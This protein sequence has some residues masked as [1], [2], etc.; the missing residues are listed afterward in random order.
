MRKTATAVVFIMLFAVLSVFPAAAESTNYNVDMPYYSYTYDDNDRVVQTPAPYY[1]EKTVSGSDIGVGGFKTLSDIFYDKESGLIYLTD[2][3]NNRVIVV[4]G[5]YKP[6]KEI[7]AE[8]NGGLNTPGSVC[9][10][11]GKIYIADT[12]NSRILVLEDKSFKVIKEL[13]KPEVK[14]FDA[15][16]KYSPSRIAVDLAGRIYVIATD[17]NDGI[18]LL[19]ENGEF[20][21]FAAAPKVTTSLWNKFLKLF[22]T[23][24]QKAELEKS[25]PTEYSSFLMDENGFLYLTSSDSTVHPITKLNSQGTDIL[26][27]SD[28]EYP[29]GDASHKLNKTAPVVSRFVDIT[30]RNDGIYASIDTEKGRVF[31]YDSEGNMIYCFGGIGTQNG[32]FYS[33]SAIEFVGDK[34]LVTDSFYGTVTVFAKTDFGA[35]ADSATVYM[36][37]GDYTNAAKMW[38]EVLRLCPDYSFAKLNLAR[39]DIQNKDYKAALSKLHGTKS[40]SYYSKA[41]KGCRKEFIREHFTILIIGL[42]VLA[43]AIIL[44]RYALRKYSVKERLLKNRLFRELNYSNHTMFHP[45]DGF[46][47]LKREKRGSFRAANI[48]MIL[49]AL[50]YGLRAQFSG[51]IFTG[52]LQS[53]INAV[54]ETGKVFIPLFLWIV[55]NWCFTTLMDGEGSMKDIYTATAYS[56]KPYIITAVPLWLLSLCLTE[57]EAFIYTSLSTIVTVWTLA[58]IF[59][60]MMVTHDYTLSKGIIT[61]VLTLVGICLILFIAL[62]FTNII[63]K[64]YDFGFD[65]YSE[66]NYRIT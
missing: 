51:Y 34:L 10:R 43:A 15:N 30:V 35:A 44:L 38:K 54:F 13:K 56:L 62:T 48:L 59:F 19:N 52:A 57:E 53:Q 49:F 25:V 8:E 27:Y 5:N 41:F 7:K 20:I 40:F 23:K 4:N 39:V 33:P 65:I 46:W 31:V 37:N 32:T 9:V 50:L 21:R 12:G 11:D 47:D 17:I 1:T 24:A 55:S 45:F 3:V 60:S 58:L 63:Q 61:A 6:I 2:S 16:Y 28:D 66:M 14:L 22:M 64:I 29:D 42:C 36:Q 18:L 26:E